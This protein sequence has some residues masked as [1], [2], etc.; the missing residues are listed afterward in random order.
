MHLRTCTNF[1]L[2]TAVRLEKKHTKT[3]NDLSTHR[4]STKI[5][6]WDDV[7][8]ICIYARCTRCV[9]VKCLTLCIWAEKNAVHWRNPRKWISKSTPRC[10][11]TD[12]STRLVC[13]SFVIR[14][15]S[16]IC[17][18][19]SKFKFSAIKP[20][21]LYNKFH[22]WKDTAYAHAH[23]FSN[24]PPCGYSNELWL[25]YYVI[26]CALPLQCTVNY[27]SLFRLALK[28]PWIPFWS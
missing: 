16:I 27:V 4:F 7:I 8:A 21:P 18:L 15:K 12:P 14:P 9:A 11:V 1:S 6:F 24:V 28:T 20:T 19:G 22:S 17:G 5:I 23:K 3:P 10:A 25:W 26:R 13:A 2:G